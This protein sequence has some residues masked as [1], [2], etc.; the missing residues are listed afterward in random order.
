[1]KI[2][3]EELTT[4]VW[5]DGSLSRVLKCR[6]CGRKNEVAVSTA[7]L[8]PETCL[9]G[10]CDKGLLLG[11][12]EALTGMSSD[13][14]QHSLD[15]GALAALKAMP[16]F[17]RLMKWLV[18]NTVD[19]FFR[20]SNMADNLRCGPDQF[21]EIVALAESARSRLGIEFN[22][23]IYLSE[24]PLGNAGTA[25]EED[26]FVVVF[27]GLLDMLD[28][29]ELVAVF[30][31]E[32][33]HQHAE[34]GVYLVAMRVLSGGVALTGIA[35][36]LTVPIQLALAK[37]SRCAELTC[38]RA[39]L[40]SVRDLEASLGVLMAFAGGQRIG[41]KKRTELS[42]S[43]FIQQARDLV[44]IESNDALDGVVSFLLTKDRS[45]PYAAWRV[46]HLLQWIEHG[47]YLDILAGDYQRA[48]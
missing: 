17:G 40:L 37:W 6:H 46:M 45:H 33:G 22:P 23:T 16:G 12:D 35:S 13:A 7:V 26:K 10:A 36:L 32:F 38:D 39:G 25:G 20:V 19:R 41:V 34:H 48:S 31:H 27:S 47:N 24:S 28:D 8:A 18:K 21:P 5:P 29:D 11:K 2:T 30:G 3:H 4:A 42:L 9:C 43:A 15:R 1:M 14:Y 44:E